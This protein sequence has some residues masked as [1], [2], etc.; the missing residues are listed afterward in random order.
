LWIVDGRTVEVMLDDTL[1]LASENE[2]DNWQLRSDLDRDGTEELI[3][4]WK[5]KVNSGSKYILG[6]YQISQGYLA[7]SGNGNFPAAALFADRVGGYPY[8]GQSGDFH[9]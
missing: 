9:F 8:R 5:K 6:V 1:T 3:R 7:K 4:V 2:E